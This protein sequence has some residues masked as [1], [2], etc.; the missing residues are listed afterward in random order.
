MVT[1]RAR[2]ARRVRAYL[3]PSPWDFSITF[4]GNS[5]LDV[6]DG[7]RDYADDPLGVWLQEAL[8][9]FREIGNEGFSRAGRH[10]FSFGDRSRALRLCSD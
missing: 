4:P 8:G 7:D 3:D 2:A 1:T 9:D 6:L 5:R 10:S